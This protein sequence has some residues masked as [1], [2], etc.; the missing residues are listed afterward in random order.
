MNFPVTV[1]R[2]SRGIRSFVGLMSICAVLLAAVPAAFAAGEGATGVQGSASDGGQASIKD[3]W[4]IEIVDVHPTAKGR[5]LIFRYRV[6]EPEKAQPLMKK[7]AEAC[8]I[9]QASGKKCITPTMEKVGT[10]RSRSQEAIK[11]RTY[12]TLFANNAGV[13]SGA[14]VTVV[15]G[16]FRAEDLVVR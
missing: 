10:L 7:D 8:L 4:G 6:L 14:R 9:D 3:R 16:D 13:K 11:G 2:R 12:F 5:M 15:I 1:C